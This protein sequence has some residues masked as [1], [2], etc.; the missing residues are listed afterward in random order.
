MMNRDNESDSNDSDREYFRNLIIKNDM[1]AI[2]KKKMY[3]S[4]HYKAAVA[5]KKRK[6]DSST[7]EEDFY[8]QKVLRRYDSNHT[9]TPHGD[10]NRVKSLVISSRANVPISKANHTNGPHGGS[11][12][13][14]SHNSQLSS[15]NPCKSLFGST[16]RVDSLASSNRTNVPVSRANHINGPHGGSNRL[17]S[18]GSVDRNISNNSVR[19]EAVAQKKRKLDTTSEEEDYCPKNELRHYDKNPRRSLFGDANRF[20]TIVSSY[21]YKGNNSELSGANRRNN[22]QLGSDTEEEDEDND[23]EVQETDGQIMES[24][25]AIVVRV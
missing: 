5:Q 8:P 24:I 16:N 13:L 6:I 9:N 7:D 20:N 18:L 15:S 1:A 14:V 17:V 22:D 3:N 10:T 12:R 25:H 19:K 23:C 2:L 4:V 21:Q 11:N